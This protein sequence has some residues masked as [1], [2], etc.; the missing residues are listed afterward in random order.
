MNGRTLDSGVQVFP[1]EIDTILV[2]SSM[3]STVAANQGRALETQRRGTNS[4]GEGFAEKL[5]LRLELNSEK[6]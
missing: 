4:A 5:T 6:P 1:R 2:I 3:A